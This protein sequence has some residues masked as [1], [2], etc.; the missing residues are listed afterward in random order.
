VVL[1]RPVLEL[2]E[3]EDPSQCGEVEHWQ[4]ADE[5][6]AVFAECVQIGPWL[7]NPADEAEPSWVQE[8]PSGEL[9]LLALTEALWRV[10]EDERGP[11]VA[12]HLG[13]I[14]ELVAHHRV[15]AELP[16][17]DGQDLGPWCAL[18]VADPESHAASLAWAIVH[19]SGELVDALALY[20]PVLLAD[21]HVHGTGG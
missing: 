14:S 1:L 4:P 12:E 18:C 10:E 8:H 11:V 13:A 6:Q 16:L 9:E 5:S 17:Y 2:D 3:L 15:A 21:V 20:G 7:V 19:R